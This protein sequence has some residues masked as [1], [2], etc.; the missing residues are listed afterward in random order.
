MLPSI[1]SATTWYVA[2]NGNGSAGT[3]WTTAYENIQT[4]L[5]AAGNGDT[6]YL[7][8]H[9]FYITNQLNWTNSAV[10]NLSIL[11][12]YTGVGSPG[13]WN[14]NTVIARASGTTNRIMAIMGVTDV[15]LGRLTL[16]NGCVTNGDTGGGLYIVNSSNI[17][18]SSCAIAGNKVYLQAGGGVVADSVPD[19]EF[20]ETIHKTKALLRAIEIAEAGMGE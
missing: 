4:A 1:A 17:L 7:A 15:T 10:T 16:Q 2:T 13:P 11:G 9:T 5:D 18:L 14:S 6:I 12:G 19:K 8:G 20:E 3:N